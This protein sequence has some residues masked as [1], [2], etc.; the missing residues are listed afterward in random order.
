MKKVLSELDF[1]LPFHQYAPSF[2][3]ARCEIYAD[4]D[5]F[6]GEDRAGFFNTLTF[7]SVFFESPFAQSDWYWWFDMLAD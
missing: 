6:P 5:Q 7:R 1:Y 4:T 2:A 3:N